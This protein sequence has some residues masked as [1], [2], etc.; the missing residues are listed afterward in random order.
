[1]DSKAT[2]QKL[3]LPGQ[4]GDGSEGEIGVLPGQP[5]RPGKPKPS[6][7]FLKTGFIPLL[8]PFLS[9]CYAMREAPCAM[10]FFLY[11]LGGQFRQTLGSR[12]DEQEPKGGLLLFTL[13]P[14]NRNPWNTFLTLPVR[15]FLS[16][17]G[18]LIR[19]PDLGQSQSHCRPQSTVLCGYWGSWI[20]SVVRSGTACAPADTA[21]AAVRAKMIV[22]FTAFRFMATLLRV[23][24]SLLKSLYFTEP[25]SPPEA[26][27]S[28][29]RSKA[30]GMAAIMIKKKIRNAVF[31][32]TGF[33]LVR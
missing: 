20:G 12:L 6:I 10:R 8:S 3:E 11:G 1:V 24:S 19:F 14:A 32:C 22:V 27:R 16:S 31:F 26:S 28:L 23:F 33:S 2:M 13:N 18:D 4:V 21:H 15:F 9:R 29:R 5:P 7:K 30:A 25:S 17:L